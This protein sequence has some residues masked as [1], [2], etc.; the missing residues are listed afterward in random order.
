MKKIKAYLQNLFWLFLTYFLA[1]YFY[2]CIFLK[3]KPANDKI[4]VIQLAKIG[5]MVCTTPVFR[6]IK[7]RYQKCH[8]SLLAS[9]NTFGV[10]KNNHRLDDVIFT[11]DY[12]G[13]FG[14]FR[15]I[16]KIRKE[17]YSWII[18]LSPINYFANILA[19]WALVSNRVSA[20]FKEAGEVSAMFFHFNNY[21]LEYKRH[22][23]LLR[24]Y[25]TLLGFLG[26][27]ACS[28]E[29]EVFTKPEEEL[30]ASNFL[31]NHNL[32]KDDLLVGISCTSNL[33]F[34]QWELEK[35]SALADMLT[36]KSG[37]RIILIGADRDF[38]KN[39]EVKKM[40][41]NNSINASGVFKLDELA[42]F[43]KNLKLFISMD[44]GPLYIANAVGV[45]V[46]NIAGPDDMREQSPYGPSVRIVQKD[47][48]CIPC[49]LV[50]S[51]VRCCR[52]GH[53]RCVKEIVPEEVFLACQPLLS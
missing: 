8:L 38:A 39:E 5:D 40:M 4:L 1:P 28:E 29:R 47:L 41:K 7:E 35:F 2:L 16:K 50:L 46:V 42:A 3:S 12:P 48:P 36:E 33:D 15:L 37:A 25:L 34:R 19:F 52:E 49:S 30:K 32:N 13:I 45:P 10:V 9:R 31:R 17:N 22:A 51:G 53:L 43:M 44:T 24:H 26:I 20:V 6:E 11:E 18:N 21:R 27:G 14:Q 23:S